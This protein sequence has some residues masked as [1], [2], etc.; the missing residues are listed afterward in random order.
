MGKIDSKENGPEEGY[1][2]ECEIRVF[3]L[4]RSGSLAIVNWIASM[5]PE[6]VYFFNNCPYKTYV[7]PFRANSIKNKK[8]GT[9]IENIVVPLQKMKCWDEKDIEP[10]RM[11][12]KDCMMYMYENFDIT[13]AKK[14]NQD[15]DYNIGKSRRR[16]DVLILR[17]VFNWTA[18]VMVYKGY[19]PL[20][21]WISGSER[22]MRDAREIWGRGYTKVKRRIWKW[23]KY[24][25][26]FLGKSRYLKNEKICISFNRWFTD[27]EYR[28]GIADRLGLKY[29]AAALDYVGNEGSSFDRLTYE[30]R[31]QEMD[32]LNRW[33]VLRNNVFYQ[34]I[35]KE[36]K[37]AIKLSDRIF[38]R[39]VD[40]GFI[41][42]LDLWYTL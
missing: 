42:E 2:N 30:G 1:R 28:I 6:P 35:L 23:E 25:L 16:F 33:K 21:D 8:V 18:S 14:L 36:N 4:P 13:F 3:H 17:D 11:R 19:N 37:N 5:F 31:A 39:I 22:R 40:D 20:S 15:R 32:C 26:E 41:E 27:E 34:E 12:H 38:G 29:S 9:P 7:D 10:I 24:A